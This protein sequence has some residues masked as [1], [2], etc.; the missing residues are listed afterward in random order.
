MSCANEL[1]VLNSVLNFNIQEISENTRFWM[2]RTKRGYFY[3]EFIVKKF[4]ALAWNSITD[5][6][7][8]TEKSR[9][10]LKDSIVLDY[11][12][13]KRPSTVINKCNSFIHDVKQNDI[14]VIP[15]VGSA[16]I[17]FAIAG[18]YFEDISKTV[19]L[20]KT[21]IRRIEHKDVYINEVSCPYRKRRHIKPIRTV[22]SEEINYSLFRAISNYHGI[23]NLDNYSRYILNMI[24]NVY[25]YKNNINII[26]NVRK[27]GPIGP[28]LLSGILY[29]TTNYL[30]EMGIA[31]S[32]ISS[33]VNINSPGPIDFSIIDIFSW[34]KTNY[35]PILGLLVVAG[36]GSFLTFKLPGLPQIIRDILTLP[37]DIKK[38][39][40]ETDKVELEVLEKKVEIYEKIKST[41]INTEDLKKSLD[42]IMSNTIQLDVQ[43]VEII[44]ISPSDVLDTSEEDESEEE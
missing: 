38:K 27:Q 12:E 25:S 7:D 41:G 37:A 1:M 33:Q 19:E 39:N 34:L 14:L 35:L 30:C 8:F 20:E 4:V 9:E 13:I 24:Y 21:I 44:D 5:T 23:S 15:S 11:P 36:G 2:I 6:T 42:T 28:R 31:E 29:G 16:Y 26:F 10:N 17:T 32:K 43:P 3:N 22:K 18:E 40:L